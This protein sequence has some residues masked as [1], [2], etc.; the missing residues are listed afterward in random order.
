[1]NCKHCKSPTPNNPRVCDACE[2]SGLAVPTLP[3]IHSNGTGKQTLL[4]GYL[5][6]YHAVDAAA[7]SLRRVEFNARDYYVQGPNAWPEAVK[8]RQAMFAKLESIK[9]ELMTIL[10]HVSDS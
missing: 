1:M 6:A 2:S 5:D 3:T 7:E 4:D 8:E 9:A 10:E